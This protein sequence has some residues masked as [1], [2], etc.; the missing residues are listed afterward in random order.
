[1]NLLK[2]YLDITT[3]KFLLVGVVNTVVGT[4]LMFL[5]YNVFSVSYWISSASNYI[6]GSI[7]SY[8]LNKYFTFQ[9]KEKSWKQVL[10]FA[11]NITCCYLLAYGAAKPVVE[12]ILSGAGEKIQGNVSMLVGMGLFLVLNYLGQRLIVFRNK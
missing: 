3:L 10:V 9:N 5:L 1:M 7:V 4:G 11:L 12:Y 6:V 2:K 8:F